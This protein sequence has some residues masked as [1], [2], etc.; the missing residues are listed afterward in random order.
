LESIWHD[1]VVFC[2]LLA[3]ESVESD[4]EAIEPRCQRAARSSRLRS[5]VRPHSAMAPTES[6]VAFMRPSRLVPFEPDQLWQLAREPIFWLDPT[7][8][9]V[10]VN[11]AWENLTG[12]PA[13]SVVGLTCQAHG[14][15]RVGD[16]ADLA[17]S[18]HPPPES[19]T[20]QPAGTPS[21]IFHVSGEATWHRLEFWPFRDESDSLIGLLGLVRSADTPP[22]VV[23]SQASRLHVELLSIRRRLQERYGFDSLVG[24]GPSHRRLL[25]QVRL[26][27]A[28]TT[29]VLIVGE[30]GTG[31]RQVA[32]TI[33]QNGPGRQK[34]LVPF[35][36]EALPVEILERE[37]F[38]RD[39]HAAAETEP[40]PGTG[41]TAR[42]R[43]SL[44]DGSTLLIREILMLPRD[45][46]ERLAASLDTPVR[47]LATTALD[48]K[49]ALE[50]EQLRPELYF[51]L[52]TLVVRLQP[53]RERRDE[54]P[55][56]AQ[57]FLE[58]AN[59]R[60]GKQKTAFSPQAISA[61][62]AYDWPGNLRELARVVDHAH[63]HSGEG[64]P[65]IA[66]E[67]LPAS[68]RGHLGGGYPLPAQLNPIKPLDELLMEVERRL[69]ET[70][71]RQARGNKSRAAELLGISRPRL[72]RRIK[73]LNLPDD[74]PTE[75]TDAIR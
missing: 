7:L 30:A 28:S 35:D 14:P 46:Q 15:T 32:R 4:P 60:G 52:T 45:L 8:R 24:F 61:L 56:L 71:L 9:M 64:G 49:N 40:S 6:I 29:P 48:P 73:E 3:F 19:L 74:E 39:N 13:D 12:Y 53:L 11:R 65:L 1:L 51:A 67:D 75:E 31:K 57:H 5:S 17:A 50:R 41:G 18:F 22:S 44:G 21:L 63:T 36:C 26:A 16:L 66:V 69:I 20:G 38:G 37:L 72:Y 43:L 54:L 55:P 25:E 47:L 58:R 62:M 27:A 70:A 10:W 33:H 34:P 59:Q 42:P 2:F 23:D 68:I